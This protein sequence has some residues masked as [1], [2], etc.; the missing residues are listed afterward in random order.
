MSIMAGLLVKN[1]DKEELRKAFI[2]IDS[3]QNGFLSK[4]EIEEAEK[5]SLI[6][7][8]ILDRTLGSKESWG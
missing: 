6:G 4:Q 3:D 7:T 5:S 1:E 2:A 8:S